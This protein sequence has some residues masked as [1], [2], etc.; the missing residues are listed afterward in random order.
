[1]LPNRHKMNPAALVAS[2]FLLLLVFVRTGAAGL[3]SSGAAAD[4]HYRAGVWLASG[5]FIGGADM[6]VCHNAEPSG[7]LPRR[8]ASC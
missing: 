4:D 5:R 6:P 7:W 8:L 3:L 2:F 1:M